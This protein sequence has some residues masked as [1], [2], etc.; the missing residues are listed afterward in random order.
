[1]LCRMISVGR[2]FFLPGLVVILFGC[3][4]VGD[5]QTT[6]APNQINESASNASYRLRQ[7]HCA[8]C[9]DGS[10]GAPLPTSVLDDSYLLKNGW[11]RPGSPQTSRLY[12]SLFS[13]MPKGKGQLSDKDREVFKNWILDYGLDRQ[14]V[15]LEPAA[16]N[17]GDVKVGS[18]MVMT[19]KVKNMTETRAESLAAV[20]SGEGFDFKDGIFPGTAGT[21]QDILVP[22]AACDIVIEFVPSTAEIYQGKIVVS[23]GEATST[24]FL[25]GI[26]QVGSGPTTGG[27]VTY[28]QVRS[29]LNRHACTT[30]HQ[31]AESGKIGQ[32]FLEL[33]AFKK[34]GQSTNAIVPGDLESRLVRRLAGASNLGPQM[35][36]AG[37]QPMPIGDQQKIALWIAQGALN[38]S[39]GEETAE[40]SLELS[41][42]PKYEFDPTVVGTATEKVISVQN[43]GKAAASNLSLNALVAPFSLTST[44]PSTL[45]P[46]GKCAVTVRYQPSSVQLHTGILKVT[47]TDGGIQKTSSLALE[48]RGA[49]NGS[50]VLDG[51]SLANGETRSFYSTSTAVNDV[52]CE[53]SKKPRKC[54]SGRLTESA[55]YRF[56]TCV[57]ANGR[58]LY[59]NKCQSCHGPRESTDKLRKSVDHIK[60]AIRATPQM[61]TEGLMNLSDVEIQAIANYLDYRPTTDFGTFVGSCD[62]SKDL[63][64][65]Y[66]A[67]PLQQ[68]ELRNSIDDLFGEDFVDRGVEEA[69]SLYPNVAS[70][71]IFSGV[72]KLSSLQNGIIFPALYGVGH[73]IGDRI[74]ES[75]SLRSR[76]CSSEADCPRE[77]LQKIA[78]RAWR[79]IVPPAEVTRLL[80]VARADGETSSVINSK[81]TL[82]NVL[83]MIFSSPKFFVKNELPAGG[84]AYT[85]YSGL[86]LAERM[87]FY[88]TSSVP[89][90]LL[91][92]AAKTGKLTTKAQ[93]RAHAKRLLGIQENRLR[94]VK[95]F[96]GSWL[97]FRKDLDSA[98]RAFG[99]RIGVKDL[100]RQQLEFVN[101]VSPCL[102]GDCSWV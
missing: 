12:Q 27:K 92:E 7:L 68:D 73:A 62:S 71:G 64:V 4:R 76:F 81:Q 6:L 100:S 97:E 32:T 79:E 44:C 10:A 59:E 95:N 82:K 47:F 56:A 3:G 63:S 98:D 8:S 84:G 17:F 90:Q 75:A 2:H 46:G 22:G 1:M 57:V 16:I 38:D 66:T 72:T 61:R 55:S 53:I 74:L 24:S 52:V 35:E 93:I 18:Q 83:A 48:G 28:S 43:E 54:V 9:H 58:A 94:F 34:S 69:L 21:C 89:D 67:G 15:E 42:L 65:A 5:S 85:T 87:S 45:Q 14:E 50:C 77:I 99:G 20:I 80:G 31:A 78:P 37:G 70:W 51:V 25:S 40:A 41:D 101:S 29:I 91:F 11:I 96:F 102:R 60:D 49:L 36:G 33:R 30:C 26:G 88:L 23:F 19:L 86:P 13:S 39:G